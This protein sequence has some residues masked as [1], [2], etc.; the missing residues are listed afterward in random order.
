L[1]T[2]AH[3]IRIPIAAGIAA[4]FLTPILGLDAQIP[5]P[6]LQNKATIRREMM[7]FNP[8]YLTLMAPRLR[9]LRE[10]EQQVM[11]RETEMRDVSCS[12]QIV[13]E[14]RWL[15]G[16]TVDT[17]R[18]DARLDDLRASLAHPERETRAREQDADG[19]WGRCYD[20]WFF[21][22]DASYDGHFS[23]GEGGEHIPLLDRVN[24]P[25]KLAQYV[26]SIAVSDVAHSGVDHRREMN[27][28]L[29][30][31]IRLIV[32][33]QPRAYQWEPGMK[34]TL[35]DLLKQL[36]NPDT[37]W[38]GERYQREGRIDFVDDMSMTFH[39]VS[40]LK[41][42]VSDLDKV[43]HTLL[44]LK[45]LEYPIGWLEGGSYRTHHN[46]DV[47]VLFRYAWPHMH[48]AERRAASIEIEKML[49][50]CL[51]DSVLPDGSFRASTGGE[52]SLE[53]NEYFGVA[54][55][56]RAGYFDASRRFWTDQQFPEA[57]K[58][59]RRLIDFIERHKASG[60]AGGAYYESALRELGEAAK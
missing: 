30:T 46:M 21:R 32:R 11:Q 40:Y 1:D 54:F 41:G 56:A 50:W 3:P 17:E 12:H 23:L 8:R 51:K 42:E 26:H 5:A 34:A 36:R 2:R 4:T 15:M 48:A 57:E 7:A 28:A 58:L 27:E 53:E 35:L 60:A 10:L 44:E 29:S 52:D 47:V 19:S 39:I 9:A 22:L 31:L 18:I 25:Q 38:W 45:D 59:R 49:E 16:S 13:T 55:L 14:L 24:S 43:G 20:A 6:D 33:G 37:G